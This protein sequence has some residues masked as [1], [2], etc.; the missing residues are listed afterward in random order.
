MNT[1]HPIPATLTARDGTVLALRHWPLPDG[2]TPR[3]VACLVH[4]LGEYIE[5]YAHVAAQLNQWGWAVVGHDHRG[6]G[7]SQ[8]PHGVLQQEDDLLVDLAQVLDTI[9]HAYPDQRLLMIGHSLGGLVASRFVAALAQPPEAAAWSR[10]IDALVLSSPALAFDMSAVQKVLIHTV[11]RLTPKLPVSNG[12]NADWV[13]SD[14]AV[15]KAYANDPMI[16]DRITPRL[17]RFLLHSG[18]VVQQRAAT[19]ATPTLLI[20][21]G[22]DRCVNPAGSARFSANA[23]TSQVTTH[24]YAHM[25]HELFNEPDQSL[26]FADLGRWLDML[27]TPPQA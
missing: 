9:R 1:P 11:G 17:T 22:A 21:A 3:G 8:G 25:A 13:C 4:G 7:H 16:H 15:V 18:T 19:W 20:Y 6:H 24:R 2:V 5:R 23:P 14:P 26:V 12:L 27:D 10:P